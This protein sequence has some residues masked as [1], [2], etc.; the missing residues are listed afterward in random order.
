MAGPTNLA[1]EATVIGVG[2]IGIGGSGGG[3]GDIPHP[4]LEVNAVANQLNFNPITLSLTSSAAPVSWAWL[5]NG[6]TIGLS[7]AT[8]ASP[9]FTPVL[10]GYYTVTCTCTIGSLTGII[11]ESA[12]FLIGDGLSIIREGAAGTI[13]AT[14]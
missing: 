9:V 4:T 2:P 3:G 8:V 7:D 5:V 12:V 1:I 6:S 13:I 11:A 14:I 10:P